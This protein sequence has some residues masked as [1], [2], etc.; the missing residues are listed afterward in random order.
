MS[1]RRFLFLAFAAAAALAIAAATAAARPEALGSG[2][3]ASRCGGSLWRLR[4]LSDTSRARVNMNARVSSVAALA[5]M[6]APGRSPSS[7]DAFE[8]QAYQV[9]AQV[10][11]FRSDSAGLHLVLFK[12]D[13]YM[14]ATLPSASCLP[15][16]ARAR[17]VMVATRKWFERNCGQSSGSWRNLGAVVRVTGV[18]FWGSKSAPSAAANGAELAPVFGMNPVAGCGAAG[19]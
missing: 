17:S 18:G 3:S 12:D 10:V 2:P 14:L 19:G 8:R 16:S 9:T 13:A 4:T 6:A 15:S 5:A 1:S 7:R 11:K